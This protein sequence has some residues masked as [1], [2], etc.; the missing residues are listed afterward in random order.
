[1]INAKRE[2]S[3]SSS[4]HILS[5]VELNSRIGNEILSRYFSFER[6]KIDKNLS[7]NRI[8]I[9]SYV[10]KQLQTSLIYGFFFFF[11]TLSS[12]IKQSVV[13]DSIRNSSLHSGSNQ[14]FMRRFTFRRIVL[15]WSGIVFNIWIRWYFEVV[16]L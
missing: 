10:F 15:L 3:H 5:V 9:F 12:L 4:F 1:M 16:Y 7:R 6:N 2:C 13:F 8:R 11:G 14:F